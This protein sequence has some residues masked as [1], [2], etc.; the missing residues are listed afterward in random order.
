MNRDIALTHAVMTEAYFVTSTTPTPLP[1]TQINARLLKAQHHYHQGGCEN[2]SMFVH[3]RTIASVRDAKTTHHLV[4]EHMRLA[5]ARD[6]PSNTM[7]TLIGIDN[8]A[9]RTKEVRASI[10]S[11]IPSAVLKVVTKTHTPQQMRLYTVDEWLAMW[12]DDPECSRVQLQS[13]IDQ[14]R[15]AQSPPAVPMTVE[16]AREEVLARLEVL[17]TES[18]ELAEGWL[19]QCTKTRV[20]TK[21]THQR[22]SCMLHPSIHF[23]SLRDEQ[24]RHIKNGLHFLPCIF[25]PQFKQG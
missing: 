21:T 15:E 13:W 11:I 25:G 24:G 2:T 19:I 12:P 22:W 4:I 5:A 3:K 8:A 6:A 14:R 16:T 20:A 23:H 17:Y 7:E 10:R 9:L 1:L 18:L